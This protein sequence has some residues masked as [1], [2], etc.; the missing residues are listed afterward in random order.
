MARRVFLQAREAERL[1]AY[2]GL[3]KDDLERP[4]TSIE[5]ESGP[6][7]IVAIA[8]LRQYYNIGMK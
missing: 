5:L 1:L 7:R 4:I 8:L 2:Y 3:S 6:E